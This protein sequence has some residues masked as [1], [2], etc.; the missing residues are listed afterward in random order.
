MQTEHGH[1]LQ[2]IRARLAAPASSGHLRDAVFRRF[3]PGDPSAAP[4]VRREREAILEV[5]SESELALLQANASTLSISTGAPYRWVGAI[6][7]VFGVRARS[8]SSMS[9]V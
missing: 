5:S 9:M 2:E 7:V 6:A 4:E 3:E 8:A 1:T